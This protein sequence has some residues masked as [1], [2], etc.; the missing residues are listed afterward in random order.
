MVV[1][2]TFIDYVFSFAENCP[3]YLR[4][5]FET[6]F[7]YIWLAAELVANSV[8]VDFSELQITLLQ[9]FS[10]ILI[11]HILSV[12][13]AWNVYGERIYELFMKPGTFPNMLYISSHDSVHPFSRY[14]PEQP[15]RTIQNCSVGVKT[16][17]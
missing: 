7:Y 6:I 3:E 14:F 9:V 16:A 17:C 11:I 12:Y 15:K 4:W 2:I 5:F 8:F 1:I 13:I 10:A